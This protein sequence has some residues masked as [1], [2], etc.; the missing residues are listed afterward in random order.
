MPNWCSNS[1]VF[2]CSKVKERKLKKFFTELAKKEKK[3]NKGQL[4]DFCES[5][6][7]YLFDIR[8]EDGVLNYET[9]WAPNIK[10]MVAIAEQF[11]VD[12][13]Y[14]Y[15]ELM[16]QVYGECSFIKGELKDVHLDDKDYEQFDINPDDEDSWIFEGR[17]YESDYE[18]LDIL[19]ERKKQ[20]NAG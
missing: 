1:V 16:M 17:V 12:F 20:A 3:E 18:I 8:W 10:I 5:D 4:P 6:N 9:R 15:A 13:V 19:L 14:E 11:R 7:G 2:T